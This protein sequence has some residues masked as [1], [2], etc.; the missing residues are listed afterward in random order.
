MET[1]TTLVQKWIDE[2]SYLRDRYGLETA[3]RI[4]EAHVN[5][6]KAAVVASQGELL[7]V[8][9]AARESG[10]SEQ[11]LRALIAEGRVVNAG[12]KGRPRLRRGDLPHKVTPHPV[13]PPRALHGGEHRESARGHGRA[14]NAHRI[15]HGT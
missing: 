4:C 9:Q 2:A 10:Y 14:F 15:V 8:S 7:T 13:G 1:L 5:E 11:H 3:A 12:Q 6:L